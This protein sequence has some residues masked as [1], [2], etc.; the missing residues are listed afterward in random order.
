M[1]R[2]G[3]LIDLDRCI[4]CE[5]CVV[6][7]KTGR[8]LASGEAFIEIQQ[9][10]EG[11]FPTLKGAFVPH[12]CFHCT[13]AA[14]VTVCPTAALTKRD[15]LTAVDVERCSGC[16]YCVD[17][18]PFRVPTLVNNHVSKCTGCLDLVQEGQEPWCVQTCPSQALTFGPWETLLAEARQRVERLRSRSPNAQ[19]YGETEMSGLGVILILPDHPAALGLPERP[20][21]SRAINV[22]QK[23]VQPASVGLTGL[24]LIASGLAFIFARRE[25]VRELRALE[26]AERADEGV[27]EGS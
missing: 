9:V 24:T 23:T 22:W 17:A 14:C 7:C 27:E 5:A 18:C 3:I 26:A 13:D 12:R 19:L 16:G 8:E 20:T 6:A 4:G 2:Y 15:G 21:T 10:V 11:T 25:H 1:T